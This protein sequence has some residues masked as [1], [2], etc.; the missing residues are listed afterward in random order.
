MSVSRVLQDLSASEAR[1]IALAAQGLATPRSARSSS[2]SP[3]ALLGAVDRLG[4][5]Q[6]DAVNVLARAHYLPLFSRLG[7]YDVARLD[8]AAYQEPR[9]LFEY[10]GHQASLL[11]VALQ[12]LFRWRMA[13]AARGEGIYGGLMRFGRSRRRYVNDVLT[14]VRER[15]AVRAG[16]L[17]SSKPRT[18]GWWGWSDAKR[19][20]EWLFW[21]GMV[22]TTTRKSF[23]RLYDLPERVLP[24]HILGLPTP[25]LE[26][27]HRELVRVSA[28]SLGIATED[29]LADYF[30][31]RLRDVRPRVAELV[32]EGAV[33]TV[34]VEGIDKPMLLAKDARLP[35]VATGRAILSP[36]DPLV[37]YRAR[38]ERLFGFRYR[39]EI[40]T[41]EHLREH[42]Y[43]V[44]P[45]LDGETLAA[46]VDL[47]A[48][49]ADSTLLVQAVHLEP[50]PDEQH[51]ATS[52]AA[53]LREVATWLGLGRIKVMRKG[54]LSIPLRRALA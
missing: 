6:I 11:P 43:Y 4:V 45:F 53:E 3:S 14:E 1:R 42:G 51:T 22:T 48:S 50:G 17:T 25:T 30:R 36:F 2:V 5:L 38:A 18:G 28:R 15:G 19:A 20:L 40:Y 10:W 26:D 24:A 32:E 46:R 34:R 49:R 27:A 7:A 29:D 39:I 41:P 21:A 12:P 13:Q 35:R 9:A 44:L 52:L 23:E 47:K 31:L 8:R 37:W 33:R 54:A 16:E